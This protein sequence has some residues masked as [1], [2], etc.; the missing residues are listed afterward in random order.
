MRRERITRPGQRLRCSAGA[1][2]NKKAGA[3]SP[4]ERL[5]SMLDQLEQDGFSGPLTVAFENGEPS[6]V[7]K[8]DTTKFAGVPSYAPPGLETRSRQVV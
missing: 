3:M 2:H 7:S 8:L 4:R 5:E 1:G 6:E